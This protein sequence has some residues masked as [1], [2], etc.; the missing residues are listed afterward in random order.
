MLQV[1][2]HDALN[3]FS[4]SK[5]PPSALPPLA[6]GAIRLSFA[7][8]HTSC[9]LCALFV[10]LG[11]ACLRLAEITFY[12][13][14]SNFEVAWQ[15]PHCIPKPDATQSALEPKCQEALLCNG[16]CSC[17]YILLLLLCFLLTRRQSQAPHHWLE[18]SLITHLQ[19]NPL[20][21]YSRSSA[22]P[23]GCPSSAASA[24]SAPRHTFA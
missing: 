15:P 23:Q 16:L 11:L 6:I 2:F 22:A 7:E 12:A 3:V 19:C 18:V 20:D 4:A 14:A 21:H 13:A 9:V 10:V 17:S 1:L 8:V 5:E 24:R